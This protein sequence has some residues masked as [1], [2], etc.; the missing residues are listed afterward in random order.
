MTLFQEFVNLSNAS[1]LNHSTDITLLELLNFVYKDASPQRKLN[2]YREHLSQ[3]IF[4][5]ARN[6]IYLI[7]GYTPFILTEKGDVECTLSAAK[8][9][10]PS[11]SRR[12][13]IQKRNKKMRK[14]LAKI[15]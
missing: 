6:H 5:S 2:K 15:H 1:N 4:Y 14:A 10:I 12:K 13:N 9:L 8:T 7:R 3:S 11:K